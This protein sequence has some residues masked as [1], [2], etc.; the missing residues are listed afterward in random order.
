[1]AAR[2]QRILLQPGARA[3]EFRLARLGGGEASLHDL[4]PNAPF[5]LAFFKI[6]C[7]VCQMTFPYLDRIH[8]PGRLPIYGVSQNDEDDTRYFNDEFRITL[9]MLLDR[10][11]NDFAI[12]N[13]FGISTVPTMFLIER[14][15]TVSRVIEG[16]V[17]KDI[18][19]L[20]SMAGV[21]AFRNG[22]NVPAWKAG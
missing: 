22:D 21:A 18:E 8:S 12:S 14:D 3:P 2:R 7:P 20:A 19:S 9:P 11:E 6:S 1:M 4:L 17:K 13:A 15:G 10:E 5:L 16:W